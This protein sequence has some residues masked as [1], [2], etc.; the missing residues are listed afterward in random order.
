MT[1]SLEKFGQGIL[2]QAEM[3]AD[4]NLWPASPFSDTNK[5]KWNNPENIDSGTCGMILLL[6]DLYETTGDGQYLSAARVAMD[7]VISFCKKNESKNFS[8]YTGR[9]GVAMTLIR[10]YNLT[11]DQGLLTT[12]INIMKGAGGEYLD[13]PYVTDFLYDG[14]AGTLLALLHLYNSTGKGSVLE[15]IK[16]FTIKI[17]RNAGINDRG[18]YWE[19]REGYSYAASCSFALGSS[20]IGYVFAELSSYFK[21]PSL[22]I[23]HD[24]CRKNEELCWDS[25]ISCWLNPSVRIHDSETF[26][27]YYKGFEDPCLFSDTYEYSWMHGITGIG[28]SGLT[29]SK[30]YSDKKDMFDKIWDKLNGFILEDK[31]ES[32]SLADGLAGV[33]MF[34]LQAYRADPQDRILKALDKISQRLRDALK[35]ELTGGLFHGPSCGAAYF[36]AHYESS[37]KEGFTILNPCLLTPTSATPIKLAGEISDVYKGLL[38]KTFKRTISLASHVISN[39][40]NG[41]LQ[42]DFR[43]SPTTETFTGFLESLF[44]EGTTSPTHYDC[45]L[46]LLKLEQKKA[47]LTRSVKRTRKEYIQEVKR[48]KELITIFNQDDW[49]LNKQMQITDNFHILY[50]K[51][52]WTTLF[53]M[54]PEKFNPVGLTIFPPDVFS[55]MLYISFDGRVIERPIMS[56]DAILNIFKQPKTPAQAMDE[57]REYFKMITDRHQREDIVSAT[58]S[59][60]YDDFLS[61]SD[62]LVKHNLQQ[63]VFDNVLKFL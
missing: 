63:L 15:L 6:A 44:P 8:L 61:R 28:I 48:Y 46:D 29:D 62:F 32:L 35:D 22:L 42:N 3:N 43:K 13:S 12:A 33:G 31:I 58:G 40:L 36:F 37:G 55:V 45:L 5:S 19:K 56:T 11:G 26:H 34:L 16:S 47:E 17:I 60:N 21:D 14:R 1:L 4:G 18:L 52:D 50:T 9:G 24:E 38:S 7:N 23:V 59:E 54:K 20:G 49:F 53:L 41:F 30:T 51:W 27:K 25:R 2:K 57:I 39:E 10:L